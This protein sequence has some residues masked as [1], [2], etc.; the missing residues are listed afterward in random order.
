[1]EHGTGKWVVD[2][3]VRRVKISEDLAGEIL[4]EHRK[5]QK[6]LH[7]SIRIQERLAGFWKENHFWEGTEGIASVSLP[8][9]DSV[10][11]GSYDAS[12]YSLVT[13]CSTSRQLI[14]VHSISP[15]FQIS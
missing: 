12:S 1:M 14:A 8:L 9:W 10:G 7:R 5:T 6:A 11:V 15:S 2:D 3:V 4:L 13:G